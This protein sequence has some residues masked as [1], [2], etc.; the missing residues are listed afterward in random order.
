MSKFRRQIRQ[1]NRRVHRLKIY[2]Q[3][4]CRAEDNDQHVS[5]LYHNKLCSD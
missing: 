3:N 5:H 1:I 4:G 2:L